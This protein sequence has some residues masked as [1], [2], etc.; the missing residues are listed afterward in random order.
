VAAEDGRGID[1]GQVGAVQLA[2]RAFA[3]GAAVVELGHDV[4][5]QR[6]AHAVEGEA[7][8]ELGHEQHPQRTRM[9]QGLG[10]LGKGG[11]RL[12][13][14]RVFGLDDV[15]AQWYT[16]TYERECTALSPGTG[17]ESP[18]GTASSMHGRAETTPEPARFSF[19]I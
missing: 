5:H 15:G 2:G 6:P 18:T 4:Q 19:Y 17:R 12:P 1:Q 10:E 11:W 14:A 3:G 9:T 16:C 13:R 7:L 8:P